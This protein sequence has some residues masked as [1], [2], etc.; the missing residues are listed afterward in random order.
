MTNLPLG[1][2]E[3]VI[4]ARRTLILVTLAVLALTVIA[5]L[6]LLAIA[7]PPAAPT[8]GVEAEAQFREMFGSSLTNEV[9]V[10]LDKR[11]YHRHDIIGYRVENRTEQTIWFMDQSFGV[12]GFAYNE[13]LEQWVELDLG[14]HVSEPIAKA[15][16]PGRWDPLD[17][18]ALWID[19]ID[20]PEDGRVRLVITGHTNLTVPVLDQTYVAYAD[21]EV[22]D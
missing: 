5:P 18:Y 14:F 22:V 10:L 2:Q 6:L 8:A 17:H 4:N 9:V 16:E 15:I 7:F 19:T 3:A 1:S 12:Q 13:N 11:K 20:L 21:V